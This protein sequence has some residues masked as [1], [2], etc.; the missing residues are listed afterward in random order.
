MIV[1]RP[2]DAEQ[3]TTAKSIVES[4]FA[5]LRNVYVPRITAN[6]DSEFSRVVAL[7]SGQVVGTVSYE[8]Q[9]SKLHL[10]DFAVD[11]Q[12]RRM[13]VG[14]TLVQYLAHLA[15]AAGCTAASLYTVAQTGN[16]VIFERLGFSVVKMT[17]ITWAYSPRGDELI[18]ALMERPIALETK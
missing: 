2:A 12:H 6:D 3:I 10:R 7:Y 15:S 18:E 13:G 1:A 8:I 14:R 11:V 17:P 16:I 9:S 5:E 4:S